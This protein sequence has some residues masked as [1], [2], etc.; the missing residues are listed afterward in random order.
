MFEI[1]SSLR[2]STLILMIAIFTF[3]CDKDSEQPPVSIYG[4]YV[5]TEI[6]TEGQY[7]FLN[8]GVVSSDLKKQ[9]E[10]EQSFNFNSILLTLNA[11]SPD[12]ANMVIIEAGLL[13][14]LPGNIPLIR[15]NNVSKLLNIEKQADNKTFTIVTPNAATEQVGAVQEMEMVNQFQIKV[16]VPQRIYDFNTE[17]W[18]NTT[19]AY[20]FNRLY[21]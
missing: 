6:E 2:L 19:V 15:Y 14:T 16:M 17:A 8:T 20:T 10:V 5:L 4:I 12:I 3:S 9:V 7:D 21:V 1:K 18:V 11:G 13:T